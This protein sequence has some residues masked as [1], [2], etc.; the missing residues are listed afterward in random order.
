MALEVGPTAVTGC[1]EL[2]LQ[3]HQDRRGSF[4]KIFHHDDF[5]DAGA[6]LEIR[7]LFFSRSRPGVVRGLHFQRPPAD[8]AKLVTC[9]EGQ[10]LDA[11]VDLRADSPTFGRH[12]TVELSAAAANAVYVPKGCAH[13]FLVT[14]TG[15][16]LMAYAQS[17]QHEPDLEGGILWSAAGI[18]WGMGPGRLAEVV[19]SDRDAAFPPLAELQSPFTMAG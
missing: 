5:A 1:L 13:G 3:P 2:R 18:D 15:D 16:A 14:G 4:L 17:G 6:D 19:V 7:E 11:V 8:V 9:V 12:C 10:V